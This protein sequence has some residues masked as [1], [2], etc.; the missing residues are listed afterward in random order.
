M[1]TLHRADDRGTS[2]SSRPAGAG[3]VRIDREAMYVTDEVFLYRVVGVLASEGDAL[4]ELEDCYGLD[5][6]SAPI[7]E[8]RARRVRVV[9]PVPADA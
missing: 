1:S 8:L 5:V 4:A 6:V 7:S 3:H 2:L 9:I